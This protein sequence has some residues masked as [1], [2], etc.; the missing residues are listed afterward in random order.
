MSTERS[1][2]L[3]KTLKYVF[4]LLVDTSRLGVKHFICKKRET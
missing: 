1:Y 3:E 4:D 2:T